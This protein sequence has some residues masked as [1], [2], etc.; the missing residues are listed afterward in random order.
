MSTFSQVTGNFREAWVSLFSD[1]S[2]AG[3]S[4]DLTVPHPSDTQH[5]EKSNSSKGLSKKEIIMGMGPDTV[6]DLHPDPAENTVISKNTEIKGS[7]Y[8]RANIRITGSVKGNVSSEANVIISGTVEGDIM[9]ES[10]SIQ[11]GMVYGNIIS[12]TAVVVSEKSTVEGD[13]KCEKFSLNSI[14][15]GNVQAQSSA[16]LESGAVIHG[17]LTSQYL[18]IQEG[19][20]VDGLVKVN[21]DS[22]VP[23]ESVFQFG[24]KKQVV[25]ECM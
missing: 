4:D 24:F 8:S 2:R 25:A 6:I 20:I 11:N 5:E 19:A 10:V 7:L 1:Q 9:G 12:K 23:I 17:N 21:R 16:A 18:S 22:E 3:E 15:K 13:V 14:V